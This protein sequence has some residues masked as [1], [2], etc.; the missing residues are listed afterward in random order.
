MLMETDVGAAQKAQIF[1]QL[2]QAHMGA[3]TT[4]EAKFL[5]NI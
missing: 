4:K 5:Y 2:S 1:A 3:D